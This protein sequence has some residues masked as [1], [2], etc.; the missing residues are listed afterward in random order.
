MKNIK[1]IESGMPF[2]RN[3]E[4]DF[5]CFSRLISGQFGRHS[6]KTTFFFHPSIIVIFHNVGRRK[7]SHQTLVFTI[8]NI[9]KTLFKMV[10]KVAELYF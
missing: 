4:G 9:N 2:F 7:I 1:N 6:F 3:L 10:S 8:R 5:D